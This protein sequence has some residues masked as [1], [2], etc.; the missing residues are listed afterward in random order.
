[1]HH[2]SITLTPSL[3]VL[4]YHSFWRV[5]ELK[6]ENRCLCY[7]WRSDVRLDKAIKG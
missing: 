3:A 1:M 2:T 6:I 5:A 4:M 7:F